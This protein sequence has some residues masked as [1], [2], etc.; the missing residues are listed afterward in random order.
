MDLN[1]VVSIEKYR[2]LILLLVGASRTGIDKEDGA[3]AHQRNS[4]GRPLKA[5]YDH[6]PKESQ[7][8]NGDITSNPSQRRPGDVSDQLCRQ[9]AG[10][11]NNKGV[12]ERQ[13]KRGE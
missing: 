13:R 12:E 10:A 9:I 5:R 2:F 1:L 8:P 7:K 11:T 6:G 3:D 4:V